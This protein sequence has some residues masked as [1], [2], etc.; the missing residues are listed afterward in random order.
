MGV[1]EVDVVAIEVGC[2]ELDAKDSKLEGVSAVR[3][4][5]GSSSDHVFT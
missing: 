2:A 5:D 4:D 1:A 3:V